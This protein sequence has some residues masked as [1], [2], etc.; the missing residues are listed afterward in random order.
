MVIPM[1]EPTKPTMSMTRGE[2]DGMAKAI[3][4]DPSKLRNKQAVIDAILNRREARDVLRNLTPNARAFLAAFS[5]S[6]NITAAAEDAGITRQSHYDWIE[7][8]DARSEYDPADPS[9]EPGPYRTAF[10][11]ATDEAADRLEMEA[12]R[13]AEEGWREPVFQGG[14][15]VGHKRKYSDRLL[16]ALLE[17]HHPR[18]GKHV[19]HTVEGELTMNV[20][21]ARQALQQK[22]EQALAYRRKHGDGNS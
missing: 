16:L 2:L 15:L 8:D 4:I 13:R 6:G 22:V 14:A 7:A 3:G 1:T 12:R 21:D 9:S 17:A 10:E 20:R 19:K 18:F 11:A 5:R